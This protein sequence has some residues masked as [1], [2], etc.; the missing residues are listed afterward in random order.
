ML[1][2]GGSEIGTNSFRNQRQDIRFDPTQAPSY[3]CRTEE[4]Q[5]IP[6]HHLGIDAFAVLIRNKHIVHQGH[7]EIGRNQGCSS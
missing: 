1:V 3:Q 6:R 4:T 5:Q 7:G 2:G